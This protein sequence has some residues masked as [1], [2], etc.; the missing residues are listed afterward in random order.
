MKL[1]IYKIKEIEG[2]VFATPD[3]E[4]ELNIDELRISTKAFKQLFKIIKKEDL[5]QMLVM[6]ADKSIHPVLISKL[7]DVLEDE[8]DEL[9]YFIRKVMLENGYYITVD[10]LKT[11]DPEDIVRLLFLM[12]RISWDDFKSSFGNKQID[13][14]KYNNQVRPGV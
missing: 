3:V 12:F 1:K 9:M 7:Y 6:I 11:C 2:E 8:N 13:D 4:S 10:Q 14:P 5:N